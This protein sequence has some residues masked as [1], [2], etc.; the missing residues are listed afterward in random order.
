ML[1]AC[2]NNLHLKWKQW[3]EKEEKKRG[4]R[5]KKRK[6]KESEIVKV[7][8][9]KEDGTNKELKNGETGLI[10]EWLNLIMKQV[11]PL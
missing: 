2:D 9:E 4:W 11:T 10:S 7:E 5:T 8:Y 1:F 6:K 3:G